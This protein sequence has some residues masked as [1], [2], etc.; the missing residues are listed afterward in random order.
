MT[1][2]RIP[3]YWVDKWGN[4]Y[5]TPKKHMR[6]AGFEN[7]ACGPDGPDAWKVAQKWA[8][9]WAAFKAGKA[10]PVKVWP[11]GSIGE[12]FERFKDT[13]E[14]QSKKPRTREDWER[15]WKHIGPVFGDVAPK[16]ITLEDLS[17]W[18]RGDPNDQE[19]KG[20]LDTLGVRE[21]HRAMKVWRALWQVLA[22]LQYC[23]AEKD[24]SFGIRRVTPKGRSAKWAEGEVVRAV[25]HAWR[26]GYRGLACLI[27]IT[28]DTQFSPVDARTLRARHRKASAGRLYFDRTAEGRTKSEAAVLGTLCQ[29]TEALVRAYLEATFGEAEIHPDAF[30]FLNRSGAPYSKDTLGDDFRDIRGELFGAEEKRQLADMRRSGT[31]EAAAGEADPLAMAKKMGNTID[32]SRELQQTYIPNQLAIVRIADKARVRGRRRLREEG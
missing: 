12:G 10:G 20:L 18:Y 30:L 23:E 19:I 1:R 21:A 25:K 14:W 7:V 32:Q 4:G 6:E 9:R 2:I 24:P 3:Y 5:W 16:T 22:A 28:W 29:R 31:V 27:A 15:G 11:A 17:L 8:Y 13:G 26:R